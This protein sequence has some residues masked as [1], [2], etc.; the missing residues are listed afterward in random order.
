LLL[1]ASSEDGIG[2]SRYV[3]LSGIAA[4]LLHPGA[5]RQPLDVVARID[6]DGLAFEILAGA[7]T[8]ALAP[9][10]AVRVGRR[11]NQR[12]LGDDA[13]VDALLQ[14][15]HD[16]NRIGIDDVEAAADKGGNADGAALRRLRSKG[17]PFRGE[18][19][20]LVRGEIRRD[21]EDG[22]DADVEQRRL[23]RARFRQAGCRG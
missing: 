10:Q 20:L 12:A 5:H 21:I 4:I 17:K 1:I 13:Q 23:G 15:R 3:T 6:A 22:H 14:R 7:E 19:A 16:R 8:F 11:R 9:E 2:T 18:I